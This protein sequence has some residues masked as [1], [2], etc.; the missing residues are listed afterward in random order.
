MMAI[1]VEGNFCSYE[2]HLVSGRLLV[3]AIMTALIAR[4]EIFYFRPNVVHEVFTSLV[5]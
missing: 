5:C 3:I 2:L 4:S 1:S